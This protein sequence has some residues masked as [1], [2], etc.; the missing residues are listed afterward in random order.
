MSEGCGSC[1]LFR[2]AARALR[3]NWNASDRELLASVRPEVLERVAAEHGWEPGLMRFDG[4]EWRHGPRDRLR[5]RHDTRNGDYYAACVEEVC[6]ALATVADVA[7]VEVLV[8]ALALVDDKAPV[9][10]SVPP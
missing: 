3:K 9:A 10:E 4:R 7:P 6:E 8:K 2:L 5:I 1:E